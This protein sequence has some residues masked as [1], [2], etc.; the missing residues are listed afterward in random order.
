M[1]WRSSLFQNRGC[2]KSQPAVNKCIMTTTI[3]TLIIVLLGYDSL[4]LRTKLR[5]IERQKKEEI[6]K[7]VIINL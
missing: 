1:G 3:L 7:R 5:Y 4:K 6:R 2:R